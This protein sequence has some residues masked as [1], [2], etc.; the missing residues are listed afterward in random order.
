[1]KRT[2]SKLLSIAAMAVA[3]IGAGAFSATPAH[4][5]TTTTVTCNAYLPNS[6][7]YPRDTAGHAQL[8][9]RSVVVDGGSPTNTTPSTSRANTLFTTIS[10]AYA[11]SITLPAGVKTRLE[12]SNVK[13]FFFNDRA[14]AD[15]YWSGQTPYKNFTTGSN[16]HSFIGGKIPG[17]GGTRCGNTGYGW[18]GVTRYIT[19]S[20]YNTCSYDNVL[21]ISVSNPSLEKS[22]LHETGHAYD[23]TFSDIVFQGNILSQRTGFLDLAVVDR[24]ALKP[25]TWSSMNAAAR[26]KHVCN[27]FAPNSN[28]PSEIERDLG[29]TTDGGPPTSTWGQVC[30]V[31]SPYGTRYPFWKDLG[32]PPNLNNDYDP[33]QIA[34][35]KIPYF[36]NNRQELFAELF[37]TELYGV[38]GPPAFLQM[39]DG[40]L[41]NTL[42]IDPAIMP[43]RAFNC[44]R[45][46]VNSYVNTGAAP[47]SATLTSACPTSNPL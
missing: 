35:K 45:T 44:T 43:K 25:S 37:V 33:I 47:S 1:M 9:T 4:A 3:V 38:Y 18:S 19:V 23:F 7:N 39:T 5:V 26:D 27:L 11:V 41:T 22:V 13:Y 10:G 40:V 6:N 21:G 14:D 16:S 24:L 28:K 46:V 12:S 20:I 36:I 42:A 8:C 34:D 15:L 29:A 30:A 31:G 32:T 2:I 17:P